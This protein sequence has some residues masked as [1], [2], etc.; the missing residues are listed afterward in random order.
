LTLQLSDFDIY[1]LS[2][3]REE[4]LWNNAVF[5][6]D[7]STLL[8]LYL[9]P[10][11]TRNQIYSEVFEKL[12][13]RLWIPGHV[14]FEYLKNRV[15]KIHEPIV[16]GY[17]PL[18]EK[19]VKPIT[20]SIIKA[21]NFLEN[22]ENEVKK[23][24]NHPH[25]ELTHI[26][27]F[28]ADIE[29]FIKVA[30]DFEHKISSQIDEKIQEVLLLEHNDT[31]LEKLSFYFHIGREYSFQEIMDITFEGKHRYEFKIPPGYEDLKD[32]VGTQ[33]FGDLIIWKQIMEYA[34]ENNR[35]IIFI[36]NDVKEDW[37]EIFEDK[38]GKKKITV[39]RKE[40]IKEI[41]DF[42]DKDFWMY[43]QKIFLEKSNKLLKSNFSDKK[44][45]QILQYAVSNAP[46]EFL[47]FKCNI[48]NKEDVIDTTKLDLEFIHNGGTERRM[49][50]ENLYV[51]DSRFGCTNCE[52]NINATFQVWE[53]PEG[54]INY[55][56][57]KL[58]GAFL[59]KESLI[60]IDLTKNEYAMQNYMLER[61]EIH[62]KANEDKEII[63]SFPVD[64]DFG[65]FQIEIEVE[66]EYKRI[67][68]EISNTSGYKISRPII[69]EEA[70]TIFDLRPS[71]RD[72]AKDFDFIKLNS[73]I[74][75]TI[76]LSV[77]EYDEFS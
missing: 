7:T 28:K 53:Y 13:D 59:I 72:F 56:K 6:F 64:I 36:C 22:L 67:E 11:N 71:D 73:P 48:C 17:N 1:Q 43:N 27:K 32:K 31:I 63:L 54:M 37:W 12:K 21:S 24:D 68:F 74:D 33:I 34:K 41:K 38:K 62:L 15:K 46:N 35:D 76:I 47:H 65:L 20:D 23:S 25:M 66:E 14:K 58:E 69:L 19:S 44:I 39:P 2:E 52:N 70:I 45:E 61:E 18:K 60:E 16:N 10:E 75:I 50:F 42:S 9:C 57:I 5:I 8:S 55:Q 30:K 51:A 4:K 3:E 49:G 26:E 40:L 29:E 77:F